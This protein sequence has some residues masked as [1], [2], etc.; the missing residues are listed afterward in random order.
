MSRDVSKI[1]P[2]KNFGGA[3]EIWTQ[4]ARP[5]V[6]QDGPG[7]PTAPQS[8]LYFSMANLFLCLPSSTIVIKYVV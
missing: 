8:R 1:R 5:P 4:V 7:Y 3:A 2:N 6:L